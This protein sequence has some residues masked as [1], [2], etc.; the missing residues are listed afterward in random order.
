MLYPFG[1][2]AAAFDCR[3]MQEQT[4]KMIKTRADNSGGV[5]MKLP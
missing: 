4:V 5:L 2:T 3:N 1:R